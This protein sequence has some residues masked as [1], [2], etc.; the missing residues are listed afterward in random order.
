MS[1]TH[2]ESFSRRVGRRQAVL[3]H[4][5][6]D[7]AAGNAHLGRQQGQGV[8]RKPLGVCNLGLLQR[9][10]ATGIVG[11]EALEKSMAERGPAGT[12]EVNLKAMSAGFEEA[13]RIS[14]DGS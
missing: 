1:I 6:I 13:E 3:D 10:L 12:E 9:D 2:L 11:R 14:N 5:R 8:R 4:E 7:E